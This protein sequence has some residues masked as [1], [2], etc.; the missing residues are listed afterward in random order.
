MDSIEERVNLLRRREEFDFDPAGFLNR[1]SE[2]SKQVRKQIKDGIHRLADVRIGPGIRSFIAELCETS[3]VAGHRAD[4]VMEQAALALAALEGSD[5]V[6]SEH[7]RHIAPMVLLH[8]SRDAEPPPPPEQESHDG[9]DEKNKHQ[10]EKREDRQQKDRQKEEPRTPLNDKNQQKSEAGENEQQAKNSGNDEQL[11]EIGPPFKVKKISSGKDRQIRRGSGRRSR[12]RVSLKQGRYSRAGRGGV[13]GDIALDAT[14]R[15]AAPYQE[16]RTGPLAIKLNKGDILFKIREKRVGNLILFIVDASGSM[17]ARGR[18]SATKGAVMSLLLDAY[19]KR[20][21]VAMI[22][23]R[24]REAGICL[25]VT[26][27]VELAGKLLAEMAVGGRTPL[28]AGLATGYREIRNYLVRE[29]TGRPIV[30][31]LTDGKGNVSLTGESPVREMVQLASGMSLEKRAK[32]IVID[33]EEEGLVTFGLAGKLAAA[34][35]GGFFKINDIQ[36]EDLVNIV[37]EKQ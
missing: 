32:Y 22:T 10:R 21:K 8:R 31:I 7:I 4:L 26:S 35:G 9:T 30:I 36:A 34:L 19:Q 6:G 37:Q 3:H 33:T 29:P 18:M 1:F 13:E 27:S 2:R 14:I 23:F 15:A 11:F 5:E 25:P 12:S 28:S 24:R 20:D 17:G 16:K